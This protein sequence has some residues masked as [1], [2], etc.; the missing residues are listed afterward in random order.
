MGKIPCISQN[1]C[2]KVMVIFEIHNTFGRKMIKKWFSAI[3]LNPQMTFS[4]NH[5]DYFWLDIPGLPRRHCLFSGPKWDAEK[6]QGFFQKKL[7]LFQKTL[8][9]FSTRFNLFVTPWNLLKQ[10]SYFSLAYS[11]IWDKSPIYSRSLWKILK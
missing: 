6:S 3:F 8:D 2:A 7:D 1:C 10:A 9:F 5:R 11:L 4:Q